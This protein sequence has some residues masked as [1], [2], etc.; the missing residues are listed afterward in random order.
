MMRGIKRE[1]SL[2]SYR[3]FIRYGHNSIPLESHNL[4]LQI[5]TSFSEQDPV[6]R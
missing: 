5:V 1:M 3:F 2:V 6:V 4:G